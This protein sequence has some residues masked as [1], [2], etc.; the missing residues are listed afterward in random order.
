MAELLLE[1]KLP[2]ALQA[3]CERLNK[4]VQKKQAEKNST[5]EQAA[6]ISSQYWKPPIDNDDG[7]EY[8]IQ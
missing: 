2:Q 5:E 1:E 7:E 3:L 4:Y 6:K 8:S